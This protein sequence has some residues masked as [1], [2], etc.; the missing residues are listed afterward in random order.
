[1]GLSNSNTGTAQVPEPRQTS[2]TVAPAAAASLPCAWYVVIVLM[3]CYT[4][5]FIDR[6]ILSLLVAPIKRDLGLSDTR[7]GL[8]QGLAFALFYALLGLPLGRFADSGNRKTLVSLGVLFWSV[9]TALCAGARNFG[10][11]FFARM[12]VGVGEATLAPGAFSLIA[13][14][15][16]KERLGL[17]LSVYS[18]GVF[19]GSGLALI[20][21]GLV[22]DFTA[23]IAAIDVPLFGS[24]ASWRFTFLLVG[25]P[26]LIAALWVA[27]LREPT[28]KYLLLSSD[29]KASPLTPAQVIVQIRARWQ[30]I[31]GISAAMV[32]IS[33]CTYAF[34]AWAPSFFQRVHHWT[35]G[36][37]GRSLGAIVMIFGC[38]GMYAG[39]TLA[40]RWVKRG[41]REANL[42]VGCISALGTL[43][44]VPAMTVNNPYVTLALVAPG[45]F[46]LA[47]PTGTTYAA[48]QLILPNQVR[49][50][51]SAL[52]LFILN[53][54]GLTL[55]PLLPALFNDYIFKSGDMVGTSVAI[56]IGM[57]ATLATILFRLVYGP[58]RKNS[59]AMDSLAA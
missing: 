31:F 45:I 57:A 33:M 16:P 39:G 11:L 44:F 55:G 36:Q 10:S 53:L 26:G 6:Q 46:F 42:R 23:H 12:G 58:Y 40:D 21:G 4:L 32:F 37:T 20:V 25:A 9:S 56:S 1:M 49:G 48:L 41:I 47:I 50:Q 35:P 2:P 13:D 34:I 3:G 24:I 7:V 38:L 30:S 28:R 43:F 27:T 51:I 19:L 17:A 52:F 15:F 59:A 18:M 14:Y 54:G 8:L 29:G 5:S 22:I